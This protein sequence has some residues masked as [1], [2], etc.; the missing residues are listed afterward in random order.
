MLAWDTPGRD[1]RMV[2]QDLLYVKSPE[3][4][5]VS[6]Q[7]SFIGVPEAEK[8]RLYAL[9]VATWL[10]IHRLQKNTF[11]HQGAIQSVQQTDLDDKGFP[12]PTVSKKVN[13]DTV[14]HCHPNLKS[15]LTNSLCTSLRRLELEGILYPLSDSKDERYTQQSGTPVGPVDDFGFPTHPTLPEEDSLDSI[16][17]DIF[18]VL[19]WRAARI[20]ADLLELPY[21]FIQIIDLH[22]ILM[23]IECTLVGESF[24]DLEL[25]DARTLVAEG[26]NDMR[27]NSDIL[28]MLDRLESVLEDITFLH[29]V[30]I[31]EGDDLF[32]TEQQSNSATQFKLDDEGYPMP[33]PSFLS[34]QCDT[35]SVLD[36]DG[37]PEPSVNTS[38]HEQY[39]DI[40]EEIVDIL[41]TL[42]SL[43]ER[44]KV[45]SF[46]NRSARQ[47]HLLKE[48]IKMF[49]ELGRMPADGKLEVKE[50]VASNNATTQ[51]DSSLMQ[52]DA[53][54]LT[55][56]QQQFL[57][58]T[59]DV[60]G[61]AP[62]SEAKNTMGFTTRRPDLY[63]STSQKPT[64][65]AQASTKLSNT[66]GTF[67]GVAEEYNPNRRDGS[68]FFA[69]G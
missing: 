68:E 31:V 39:V 33:H 62:P 21:S 27:F 18:G 60:T 19:H 15:E 25:A 41:T 2:T 63:G 51:T 10:K 14:P 8:Y 56:A 44:R 64:R 42:K 52:S 61:R 48:Q 58:T 47:I 57:A 16:G 23:Y 40:V 69:F 32:V 46:V 59:T 29:F 9:K 53:L 37:F 17:D 20:H 3:L 50:I 5:Q 66:G 13:S 11:S 7:Y 67:S 38:K 22:M 55:E 6:I 49:E 34:E 54:S 4:V 24:N 45:R 65:N 26:R 30:S 36:K 43:T 12:K 35:E 28:Q 1:N